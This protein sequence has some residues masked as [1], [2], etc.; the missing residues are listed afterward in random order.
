MITSV[1]GE[2]RRRDEKKR[3]EVRVEEKKRKE[4]RGGERG[5]GGTVRID[6]R[7]GAIK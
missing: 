2:E 3:K 6:K 7:E 4:V 1:R 5:G